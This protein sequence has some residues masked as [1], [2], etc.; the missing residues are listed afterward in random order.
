MKRIIL[1]MIALMLISAVTLQAQRNYG[2]CFRFEQVQEQLNLNDTQ[3]KQFND[4]HFAHRQKVIDLQ[5]EIQKNKL[6]VK[7]MMINNEVDESKLR[8]LTNSNSENRAKIHSSKVD[9]WISINKVLNKD[10][11]EVWAKHF[12]RMGDGRGKGKHFNKSRRGFNQGNADRPMQRRR[13]LD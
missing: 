13:M 5:A 6:A 9:M 12:A 4:L 11:K 3:E 10:Q 1:S 8:E 2:N 7:Q